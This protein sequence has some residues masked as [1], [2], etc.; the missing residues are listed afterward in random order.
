MSQ[1]EKIAINFTKEEKE[2]LDEI[3]AREQG[4]TRS[5]LVRQAVDYYLG[6]Y[7]QRESMNYIAYSVE[8][9]RLG[10]RN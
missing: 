2:K 4:V 1:Y 8:I 6:Y 7:V 10:R 9:E 3:V 5:D